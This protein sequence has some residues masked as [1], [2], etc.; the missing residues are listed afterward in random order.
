MWKRPQGV[1]GK[2]NW[3]TGHGGFSRGGQESWL[4]SAQSSPNC[5]KGA[6]AVVIS[7]H[8]CMVSSWRSGEGS[9]GGSGARRVQ[10]RIGLCI[11]ASSNGS[12]H[13]LFLPGKPVPTSPTKQITP[14]TMLAKTVV[15]DQPSLF[16]FLR[17][18]RGVRFVLCNEEWDPYN[19][20]CPWAGVS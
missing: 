6:V 9:P 20:W 18:R 10:G 2:W 3:G 1:V 15:L 8:M 17:E 14:F 13:G 7:W 19:T 4:A 12:T 11:S 5:G 16:P